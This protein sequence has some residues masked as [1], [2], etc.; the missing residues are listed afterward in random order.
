MSVTMLGAGFG[1]DEWLMSPGFGGTAAVV[2]ALV[3]FFGVS[4]TVSVQREANRKQQWRERARWAL[5][6]TLAEDTTTRAIGLE[7]L[8]ALSRSEYVRSTSSRSWKRPSHPHWTP[9]AFTWAP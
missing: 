6:L 8:D 9:T 3:A 4:R 5:D 7:V 1:W 2:A